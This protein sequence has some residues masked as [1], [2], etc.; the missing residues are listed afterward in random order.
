M[1]D[2]VVGFVANVMLLLVVAAG[3]GD[4]FSFTLDNF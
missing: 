4:A 3:W 1:E 2:S